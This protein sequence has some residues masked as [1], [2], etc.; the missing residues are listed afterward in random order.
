MCLLFPV[1]ALR[2]YTC[3]SNDN[4]ECLAPPTTFTEEEYRDNRSVPARLLVECPLDE[5]GREPFCRKFD[6]YV[7][8]G[9]LPDHTRILRECGYERGHRPCYLFENGGHTEHVCQCFTDGCNGGSQLTVAGVLL[10]FIYTIL[11]LGFRQRTL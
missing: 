4:S 2:C 9:N 1:S 7:D 6:L 10:A 11:L 5:Q 3:N 8:G